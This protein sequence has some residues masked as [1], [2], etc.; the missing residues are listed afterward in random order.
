M[1]DYKIELLDDD[2]HAATA[3][4]AKCADDREAVGLAQ[5]MVGNRGDADVWAEARRVSRVSGASGTDVKALGQ[6]WASHSSKRA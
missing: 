5:C 2:G 1:A 3:S 6:R 4:G